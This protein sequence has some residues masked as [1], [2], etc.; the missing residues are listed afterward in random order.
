MFLSSMTFDLGEDTNALR[1]MVHCWA[2]DRVKPMAAQIDADNLFPH[3][4]WVEMGELGFLGL[5]VEGHTAGP[6]CP[7]WRI[8]SRWRRLREHRLLSHYHMARIRT[9]A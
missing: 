3:D 6:I 9:F 5:T 4:L 7:I 1:D 2:Q 8:R